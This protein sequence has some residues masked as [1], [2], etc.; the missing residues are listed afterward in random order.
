M[1]MCDE[2]FALSYSPLSSRH[3]LYQSIAQSVEHRVWDAEVDGSSPSGLTVI[4]RQKQSSDTTSGTR[5]H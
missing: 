3:T 1:Y 5:D 4:I 2:R